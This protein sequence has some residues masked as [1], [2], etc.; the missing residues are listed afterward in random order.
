MVNVKKLGNTMYWMIIT[1]SMWFYLHA[2][3]KYFEEYHAKN[4]YYGTE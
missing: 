2:I 1:I 4:Y 3:S